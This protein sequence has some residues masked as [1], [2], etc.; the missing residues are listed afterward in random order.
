MSRFDPLRQRLHSHSPRMTSWSL[1]AIPLLALL[2]I[3]HPEQLQ[4]V[5]YKGSLVALAAVMGYWLDRALF[6]YG[7]P[8]DMQ[9]GQELMICAAYLRRAMVVA[10]CILGMTLGL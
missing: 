2:A 5:L 10:G 7:R 1:L 3:F 8:G 9:R 4:V 6:P